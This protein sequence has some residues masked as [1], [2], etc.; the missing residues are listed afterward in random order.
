MTRTIFRR[1][2]HQNMSIHVKDLIRL[3]MKTYDQSDASVVDT[4]DTYEIMH[5]SERWCVFLSKKT[6]CIVVAFRGTVLGDTIDMISNVHAFVGSFNTSPQFLQEWKA[7]HTVIADALNQHQPSKIVFCGHSLGSVFSMAAND[8]FR[9]CFQDVE[10][11]Q[12][13]VV[14]FNSLTTPARS[15]EQTEE[16]SDTIHFIVEK[17]IVSTWKH[18]LPGHRVHVDADCNESALQRHNLRKMLDR[19]IRVPKPFKRH[20]RAGLGA[21]RPLRTATRR[22]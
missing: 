8:M 12:S 13:I 11:L 17:D 21:A 6:R 19:D 10:N 18:S 15:A 16:V 2:D 1:L 14:G 9:F 22:I 7:L 20:I 4:F 3:C 5:S